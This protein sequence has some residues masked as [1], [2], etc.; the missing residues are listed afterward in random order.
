MKCFVIGGLSKNKDN[1]SCEEIGE[2]QND[3]KE[4]GKSIVERGDSLIICSPFEESAD[5]WVLQGFLSKGMNKI[6]SKVIIVNYDEG[7]INKETERVIKGIDNNIIEINKCKDL[8][9]RK[10]SWLFCQLKALECCDYVV[11]IGGNKEGSSQML[12]ALA[13]SSQKIIIPLSIWDGAAK[14]CYYNMEY[15]FKARLQNDNYITIWTN[16]NELFKS[17]NFYNILNK[18]CNEG[19]DFEEQHNKNY[20]IFISYPRIKN[21]DADFIEVLLR[22]RKLNVFRDESEFEAGRSIQQEIIDKLNESNIF[23]A[24]WCTEYACSPWCFD[25]FELALDKYKN[26]EN[27]IKLWIFCL[28]ETRIVPKRARELRTLNVKSREDIEREIVKLLNE[29]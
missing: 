15:A 8:G 3:C 25:E 9:S 23:I 12:L 27:S 16:P 18:I 26:N 4:I 29:L 2:F 24:L 22:R 11:A 20:K 17:S 5:Y 21:N 14:E 13:Q 1:L 28:D 7:T 6:K 10:Y 19:K